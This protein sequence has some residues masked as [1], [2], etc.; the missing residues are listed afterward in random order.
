MKGFDLARHS[1]EYQ[2]DYVTLLDGVMS[3]EVCAD[4]ARRINSVIDEGG[5]SLV[6]HHGAG[7][8]AVSDRGGRYLHHIFQGD[9]VRLH[10]PE[11]AVLYRALL[12]LVCVL[13]NREVV[14]SPHAR[15]DM[16]VKIY[17]PGG[18]TLGEHY[19]SNGITVLLFL[20]TNTEAPLRMQIPRSHPSR[21]PWTERRSIYARAGTLLLMQGR[22]VLH[23]CEATTHEQ[24]L[25]VVLNYY[26]EGDT[27]RHED[28]DDFV[29]HG[30]APTAAA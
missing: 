2:Y 26:V 6:D 29:Y 12:P 13:T 10:L 18:G 19:D 3:A 23:D 21:E 11:I 9:D 27:W 28:F 8:L 16:N 25:T 7:T 14:L 20:T 24:K 22:E 30:H 5:V 17:P 1:R 4:L 15:S